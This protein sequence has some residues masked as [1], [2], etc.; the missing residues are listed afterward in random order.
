MLGALSI[1]APPVGPGRPVAGVAVS[2]GMPERIG[3]A[4]LHQSVFERRL[5][6]RSEPLAEKGGVTS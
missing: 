3:S 4:V 5:S 1:F 6:R 2:G